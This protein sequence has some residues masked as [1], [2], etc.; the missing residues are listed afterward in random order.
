[1]QAQGSIV[2]FDGVTPANQAVQWFVEEAIMADTELMYDDKLTQRFALL[3]L[4]FAFQGNATDDAQRSGLLTN[5]V[6]QTQDECHWRGVTCVNDR[7]TQLG[8]GSLELAGT[9][10]SEI[11]LLQD[12]AYLDV[13]QNNLQGSLSEGLYDLVNLQ[14]L[15]LY[16]N[17]LTGSIPSSAG[18][19]MSM[20]RLQLSQNQ[21]MGSIPNTLGSGDLIKSFS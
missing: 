20:S 9:I 5:W 18:N 13:S 7:V 2:E 3:A 11:S 19:W 21:L 14:S 8:L 17:Q 6:V 12:L 15:Y 16:Q 10:P 4:D 1:L